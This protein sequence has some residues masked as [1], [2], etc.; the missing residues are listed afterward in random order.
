MEYLCSTLILVRLSLYQPQPI[1]DGGILSLHQRSISTVPVRVSSPQ[2]K[3]STFDCGNCFHR[4][5]PKL[6]HPS[7]K[8]YWMIPLSYSVY[9]HVRVGTVLPLIQY[10]ELH[11]CNPSP[12]RTSALLGPPER[13]AFCRT[14][15]SNFS[16]ICC[17]ARGKRSWNWKLLL[18]F[19][20]SRYVKDSMFLQ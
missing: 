13:G 15:V 12:Y 6:R 7:G 14:N 5:H 16:S 8:Q 20:G 17:F 3:P 19:T 10:S 4:H 18:C 11:Y 2:S 9:D 1:D